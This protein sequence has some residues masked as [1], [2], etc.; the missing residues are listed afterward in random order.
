MLSFLEET[1]RKVADIAMVVD[2]SGSIKSHNFETMK[3]FMA[4]LVSRFSV[5]PDE[6]NFAV[7]KFSNFAKVPIRLGRQTSQGSLQKAIMNLKYEGGWTYTGKALQAVQRWVSLSSNIRK[8]VSSH[9]ETQ[10]SLLKHC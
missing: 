1:C 7:V 10:R 9:V 4:D 5:S 6:A 8:R 2:Q 3:S